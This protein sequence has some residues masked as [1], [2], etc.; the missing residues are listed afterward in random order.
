MLQNLQLAMACKICI[1]IVNLNRSA[2]VQK[3]LEHYDKQRFSY[4]V[5]LMCMCLYIQ[6]VHQKRKRNIWRL[7][8][9]ITSL[10]SIMIVTHCAQYELYS[11]YVHLVK[12]FYL[13]GGDFYYQYAPFLVRVL[14]AVNCWFSCRV[15]RFQFIFKVDD[16]E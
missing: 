14:S 11:L 2:K 16:I 7:I 8:D 10:I 13:P 1:F 6:I 3:N 4:N 12:S 9:V 5:N 15:W